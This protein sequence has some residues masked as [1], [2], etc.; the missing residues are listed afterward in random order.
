MINAL[1]RRFGY[2]LIASAGRQDIQSGAPAPLPAGAEDRLRPDHPRLLELER[3]Y[4]Q[5]DSRVVTPLLW[6]R[7]HVSPYD[8][9]YFRGDNA[10]VWQIRDGAAET[11][12]A[13]TAYYVMATDG[14]GLLDKLGE[15]ELFGAHTFTAG[16]RRVSRDLLDSIMEIGFLERE[17][18]LSSRRD[19]SIVD[20]GAGYGRLAH[21]VVSA[22]PGV[23]AYFC[24]DAVAV[25]TFVCEYY[26]DFRAVAD[27]ARV[28]RLDNL[29]AGLAGR[30][31]DLAINVHSFS[32]CAP[33]AVEWWVELLDRLEVRHLMVVPNQGDHGG[34]RLTNIR[35]ADLLPLIERRYR[36]SVKA[37]K[38]A[39]PALQRLGIQPTWHY[40]FERRSA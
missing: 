17:L 8:L 20:I 4:A 9:R 34:R 19:F 13:L 35:G 28:L 23:S 14:L 26:L 3:A 10:Y 30:R 12:Y 33:A 24:A 39:D 31:I 36:L 32:E 18:A 25:S 16:G 21:R 27:R 38:Y 40:L 22:F 7:R 29:E 15:D 5:F 37:P 2:Q 6:E 1:L 11:N